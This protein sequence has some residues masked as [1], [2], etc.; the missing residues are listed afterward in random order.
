VQAAWEAFDGFKDDQNWYKRVELACDNVA[1]H[2]DRLVARFNCGS[3]LGNLTLAMAAGW[4]RRKTDVMW[5]CPR[6]VQQDLKRDSV[7][8]VPTK[9]PAAKALPNPTASERFA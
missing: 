9:R 5:L 8:D 6:C 2:G 3:D 4:E 1:H 7:R